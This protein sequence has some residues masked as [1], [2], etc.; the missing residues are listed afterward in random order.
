MPE[1]LD[2][3]HESPQDH[4]TQFDEV[5]VASESE[6][7]AGPSTGP[8]QEVTR[9]RQKVKEVTIEKR[10]NS[11]GYKFAWRG[12]SEKVKTEG[13]DWDKN[14]NVLTLREAYHGYIV[15]GYKP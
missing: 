5:S 15:W 10:G 3:L 12:R 4:G 13:A 1:N 9:Q 6:V 2:E 7:E 8:P 14:G 11:A